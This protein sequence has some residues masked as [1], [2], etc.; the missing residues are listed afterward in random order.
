M[1]K[2]QALTPAGKEWLVAAL[3][4]FHDF[5]VNCSGYPDINLAPSIV[6]L[7]KQ[8]V[9]IA[10]PG[11]VTNGQNWDC[12]ITSLPWP[13]ATQMA[14]YTLGSGG[15]QNAIVYNAAAPQV[16]LGGISWVS[17]PSGSSTA[18]GTAA[19]SGMGC[20]FLPDSY[21]L[22]ASRV[23]AQGFEVV[24]TTSELNSQ[25]QVLVY[26]NPQEPPVTG[27][28]YPIL[29]AAATSII[30]VA[31]L[32]DVN[33]WPASP[34]QAMLLT[35]TRQWHAKEGA[36]CALTLNSNQLPITGEAYV[37]PIIQPDAVQGAP[38]TSAWFPKLA[39]GSLFASTQLC[40]QSS[41]N[42][43]GAYFTGLSY[44]TTLSLTYNV[45]VERF[46]S[47]S[48]TDLAVL[49]KP[50]PQY[51]LTALELY[52]TCLADMPPGVMVK[53]NGLGEW[54][55]DAVSGITG[56]L[57]PVLKAIPHPYAQIGAAAADFTKGRVDDMRATKA[58][59]KAVKKAGKSMAMPPNSK[60]P[61]SG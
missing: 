3:D 5:D 47:S 29:N 21:L 40:S 8:T 30:G 58:A 41:F 44:T 22:G 20:L 42:S 26:R 38:N 48:E 49:A 45:F 4:P 16:T 17:V 2:A 53:E 36:Y 59:R 61:R 43:S 37:G 18:L 1:V 19:T 13:T 9:T 6:Q 7:V 35:G 24:N 57:A 15:A 31:S 60:L 50:S 12:H 25:G 32:T 10:V 46:P 28:S 27:A 54:F 55:A 14:Q 51:D 56:M 39:M 34:A 11:T 23:I 52:S 33:P